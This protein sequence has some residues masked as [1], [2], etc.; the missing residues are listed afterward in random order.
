MSHFLA[1]HPPPN[2]RVSRYL[3]Q[4]IISSVGQPRGHI[5]LYQE[6]KQHTLYNQTDLVFGL[7]IAGVRGGRERLTVLPPSLRVLPPL[8]AH[9]SL[10]AFCVISVGGARCGGLALCPWSS[11]A[12]SH[13]E[14]LG[15]SSHY[16]TSLP[17]STYFTSLVKAPAV[18]GTNTNDTPTSL[19]CNFPQKKRSQQEWQTFGNGSLSYR[20]PH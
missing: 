12:R 18:D 4:C 17:Q 20:K 3:L 16:Q 11:Q 19:L 8:T 7:R 13:W 5:L 14:T 10:G 2:A 9:T 6:P 1:P 15:E